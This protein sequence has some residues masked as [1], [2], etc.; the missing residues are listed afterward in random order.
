[1]EMETDFVI[2][3]AGAVVVLALFIA[4]MWLTVRRGEGSRLVSRLTYCLA[5]AVV[6]FNLRRFMDDSTTVFWAHIVAIVCIL[7][8]FYRAERSPLTMPEE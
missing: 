7:V 1:M 4:N 5:L 6:A 2:V 8:S 3:L